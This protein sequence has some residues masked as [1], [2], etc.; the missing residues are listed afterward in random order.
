ML[1]LLCVSG[2]DT[3]SREA[4]SA[5]RKSG[6]HELCAATAI[7]AERLLSEGPFRAVIIGS[8][9]FHRR[10]AAL[11]ALARESSLSV[12]LICI[13]PFDRTIEA[14]QRVDRTEGQAGLL[15]AV[16][17]AVTFMLYEVSVRTRRS[18]SCPGQETSY[19]RIPCCC[20]T[21]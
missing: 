6:Y 3:S 13:G 4:L 17:R 16:K 18:H 15:S 5:L 7:E 2:D 10:K 8:G 9:L 21:C 1:K 11:A 14:D 12:I 19:T 20:A